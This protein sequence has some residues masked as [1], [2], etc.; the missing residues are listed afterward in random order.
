MHQAFPCHLQEFLSRYL[1]APLSLTRLHRSDEQWLVD[2]FAA[3]LPTWKAGLLTNAG[4]ATLAQST[5]SAIPVHVSICCSLSP[6]AL[7]E[8]DKRRRG[9]LWTGTES[10]SSGHCRVAWRIVCYH[11]EHGGLGMPDLPVLGFALR[12]RWEWLPR[13]R[14]NVTWAQLPSK[15]ERAVASMFSASVSVRLGDGASMRFWTDSWLLDGPI[16]SFA[17]NLFRAIGRRWRAHTVRE[18]MTQHQW[19]RDIRRANRPGTL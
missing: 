10:A 5:L 12:L 15:P 3:R 6:W 4:R 14:P 7:G 2:V 16:C 19:S 1:G 11:R 8:I 13:S 17:P 9:F 18:A